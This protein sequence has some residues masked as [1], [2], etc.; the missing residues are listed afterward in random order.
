LT[1]IFGTSGHEDLGVKT[2]EKIANFISNQSD[3]DICNVDSLYDMSNSVDLNT[4]DFRLNYPLAIKRCMDLLSINESKLFGSDLNDNYNFDSPSLYDNLNRGEL[5]TLNYTV[6]AG[7]PVVLRAKS[8]NSYRIIQTGKLPDIH[9]YE[10]NAK[11]LNKMGIKTYNLIELVKLLNLPED[12]EF[13]YEFYEFVP[14]ENIVNTEN[15]IDWYNTKNI[16]KEK[17]L[18]YLKNQIS[19]QYPDSYIK[20]ST[21]NG[22]MEYLFTYE[23]YKGFGLLP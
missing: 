13:F 18:L 5:L 10:P 16:D 1:Y 21:D 6:T 14:S 20:W 11:T 9:F 22:M 3:I 2:Y 7:V 12:W 4:D 15:V 8:L 19:G 17:Y 23:L